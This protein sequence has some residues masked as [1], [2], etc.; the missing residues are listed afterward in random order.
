MLLS[1]M[2]S[3]NIT[4]SIRRKLVLMSRLS[5]LAHKLVTLMCM[6]MLAS[7]VRNGLY[8]FTDKLLL[9]SYFYHM[10]LKEEGSIEQCIQFSLCSGGLQQINTCKDGIG[11]LINQLI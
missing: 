9:K 10:A 1:T 7:L 8:S 4:I 3:L 6:L 5:S 11:N 2:S